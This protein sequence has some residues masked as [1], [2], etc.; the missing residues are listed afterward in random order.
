MSYR[1]QA[2]QILCLSLSL[3]LSL[4]SQGSEAWVLTRGEFALETYRILDTCLWG[5]FF[6]RRIV[7]WVTYE[8][9]R[10]AHTRLDVSGR[11]ERLK[12]VGGEG[13]GGEGGA[14]VSSQSELRSLGSIPKEVGANFS[15][16]SLHTWA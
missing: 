2:D 1:H 16:S 7:C 4:S 10:I 3:S 9:G 5:L 6:E 12:R 15:E 11:L 14:R 13:E 8:L